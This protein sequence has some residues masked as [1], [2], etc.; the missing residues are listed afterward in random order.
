MSVKETR[1]KIQRSI[2]HLAMEYPA[3]V[4]HRELEQI[5]VTMTAMLERTGAR[6]RQNSGCKPQDS[7]SVSA[8]ALIQDDLATQLGGCES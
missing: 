7:L 3:E 5:Q 1:K 6:V 2:A 8:D 4:A